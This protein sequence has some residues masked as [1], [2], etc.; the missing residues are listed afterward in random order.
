MSIKAI[1]DPENASRHYIIDENEKMKTLVSDEA[2]KYCSSYE[3]DEDGALSF[4]KDHIKV[5]LKNRSAEMVSGYYQS[6]IYQYD[7]CPD[8]E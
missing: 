6:H 2:I 5:A 4:Y 1:I 7:V 8:E 3:T